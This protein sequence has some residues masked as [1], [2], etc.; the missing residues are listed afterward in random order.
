MNA[1]NIIILQKTLTDKLN[2]W[3]G[4][5]QEESRINWDSMPYIGEDTFALLAKSSVATLE[6]VVETQDYLKKENMLTE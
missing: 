6:A 4:E 3:W 1:G 5:V 2:E